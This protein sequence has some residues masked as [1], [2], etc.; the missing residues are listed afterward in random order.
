MLVCTNE[1]AE[2]GTLFSAT[3]PQ[4]RQQERGVIFQGVGLESLAQPT[5]CPLRLSSSDLAQPVPARFFPSVHP[6]CEV[7]CG[8]LEKAASGPGH[9]RPGFYVLMQTCCFSSHQRE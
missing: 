2:V 9:V 5:P 3:V 6:L 4:T 1:R 7:E 8:F